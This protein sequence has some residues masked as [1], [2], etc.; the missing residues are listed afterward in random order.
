MLFK[1]IPAISTKELERKLMDK[2]Q[3]ID[4]REPHEF[5]GGHI[6]G[7]KNVPLRK[8]ESFTPKGKTYVV[9]QSGMRSKKATKMLLKK[10]ADV[11]NVRGGMMAWSGSTRGGKL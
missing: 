9:C 5:R 1:K 7:A 2:P 4:V 8:V 10:D 6:P 11:V 3:I